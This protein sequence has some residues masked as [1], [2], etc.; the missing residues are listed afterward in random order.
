MGDDSYLKDWCIRYLENKDSV[1][2]EIVSIEK[3][4]NEFDFII[5][6]K[7]KKV[8][9]LVKPIL[10]ED[11]NSKI[12][13]E[14]HFGIF[15]LNNTLNINFVY[16][17]WNALNKFKFLSI[18]FV[19][20][21]SISDKAWIIRPY[22]HERVCEKASLKLGLNSMAEMVESIRSEEFDARIKEGVKSG[23]EPGQ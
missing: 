7:E 2:R 19:N 8:Y 18:Y 14:E 10:T 20:P 4:S 6:Y 15:T 22:V 11:V 16:N 1:R 17:N 9:F 13:N 12:K 21:F 5:Q 3:N 23:P